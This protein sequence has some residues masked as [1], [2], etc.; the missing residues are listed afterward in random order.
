MGG[1]GLVC[2]V[3]GVWALFLDTVVIPGFLWRNED[4]WRCGCTGGEIRACVI[5]TYLLVFSHVLFRC[6]RCIIWPWWEL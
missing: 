6:I 4:S 5:L 1:V 2:L 3:S